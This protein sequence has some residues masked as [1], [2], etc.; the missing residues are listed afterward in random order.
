M[1]IVYVLFSSIINKFYVGYTDNLLRRIKEHNSGAGTFTAKGRPW[2]LVTTF[3][4]V[5]RK[6]AVNLELRIK[7][8]GIKRFLQDNDRA[9]TF[10]SH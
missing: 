5:D 9:N 8:R 10:E 2:I 7:K 6:T 4:C 1:M 3:E